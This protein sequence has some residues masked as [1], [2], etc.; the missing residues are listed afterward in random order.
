MILIHEFDD[1]K[2]CEDYLIS[3]PNAELKHIYE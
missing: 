2:S 1:T 3:L